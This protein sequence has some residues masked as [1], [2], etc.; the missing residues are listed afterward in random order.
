MS[1]N[2]EQF[3]ELSVSPLIPSLPDDVALDIVARVP[4]SHY[5]TLSLVSKKFRNLI[6]SSKLYKRRSQLGI[7]QHRVYAILRNRNNKDDCRLYILHRKLNCSNRLV[8]VP[9][10][11]P[12]SH[13]GSFVSVGSK[14]YVFNDVDALCIDCTSHTVQPISDMPQRFAASPM[15]SKLANV[16]GEKVYLIG[17]SAFTWERGMSWRKTVMVLDTVTQTWEPVIKKENMRVGALWSDAVV[18]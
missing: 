2:M 12:V 16:I 14:V 11:P 10:L 5:P 1:E 8:V 9:S 13:R 17:D 3:S 7:T 6:A 18:M 4:R 15:C